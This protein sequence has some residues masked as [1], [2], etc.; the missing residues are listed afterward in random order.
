MPL[1]PNVPGYEI[2]SELGRG[3][4]GVVYRA[5]QVSLN[6]PV[7]LKM[8]LAG[9]LASP[10]DVQRF[11]TEA[12]AAAN[13]DHPHVVPI[14]EVGEHEGQHYFGMKLIEGGSLGDCLPH[15]RGDP[16]EAARLLR[17]AARA[18]HYAH[19]RGL[20]HRDLKPANIL[21][22]A[23]GEP[24]VT[25]FGLAKR[26][27]S[28]GREP[29][30]DLTRTGA[31]VGTPSYM[32]P[33][34]AR[35]EKGLSTAVDVYSLGAI[36]YE[37]LT[38]HPPFH[39]ATPL[40]TILQVLEREPA[41]PR[42]LNP[43]A[44]RDL[45]TIS[46]KCLEK[47]PSRRYDSAAALADDLGRWLRGEPITARA[48]GC[49]E[50]SW[51][52]CRRNP[53]LAGLVVAVVLFSVAVTYFAIQGGR[54]AKA[55]EAKAWQALF[56]QARAERLAGNR[57]GSLE[58]IREALKI[59][60]TLELREQAVQTLVSPGIQPLD[61]LPPDTE[62]V[63]EKHY[64]DQTIP[65][66]L[67]AA[68]KGAN[69][70]A[71]SA[72]RRSAILERPDT[73][74]QTTALTLWDMRSGQ[75]VSRLGAVAGVLQQYDCGLSQDGRLF[76]YGSYRL[77]PLG[78][79]RPVPMDDKLRI[80]DTRSGK[81]QAEGSR[82]I[83]FGELWT[84]VGG[85]SP[86]FSPDGALLAGTVNANGGMVSAKGGNPAVRVWDV[87]TGATVGEVPW[88]VLTP[89]AWSSDGRLLRARAQ[90]SP[91]HK[92]WLVSGPP[93]THRVDATVS[94]LSFRPDGKQLVVNA[95]L[96]DVA[97][98]RGRLRLRPSLR[99]LPGSA[100]VFDSS[101]RLWAWTGQRFAAVQLI[102]GRIR[103]DDLTV[104]EINKTSE[105]RLTWTLR[106]SRHAP[107]YED[108][109]LGFSRDGHSVLRLRKN[110]G[111]NV[112]G[113]ELWDLAAGRKVADWEEAPKL[114][115]VNARPAFSS[116]G[117][118]VA[119]G[120]EGWFGIWKVSSGQLLHRVDLRGL[121]RWVNSVN[122]V[123]APP[124][125][126]PNGQRVFVATSCGIGVCDVASGEW[127]THWL[128]RPGSDGMLVWVGALAISP[129]GRLAATGNARGRICLVETEEG[130]ELACWE[131]QEG[132]VTALTFSPD[133]QAL[134]SG[135]G[136]NFKVWDLPRIREGL[137]DLGFDW[138][139]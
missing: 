22:D 25:D 83:L 138:P 86:T 3:G 4:M 23:K 62:F 55:A 131:A 105:K 70:L 129:D 6:R 104:Y 67:A 91:D 74:R 123:A 103:Y 50:R 93:V 9:Q 106:P 130:R 8:I 97:G 5:W 108:D 110:A 46:L 29:G 60:N 28:A 132:P 15:F 134:V 71:I 77:G 18:V 135:G 90:H 92:A 81:V 125:F 39:A 63:E 88:S 40:D 45:A 11:H 69:C 73:K 98:E 100:A 102:D 117:D 21:L 41:H 10:Q 76:A 68:P 17:T 80:V 115:S 24:H 13:L 139:E 120:G 7:A 59:N 94:T 36:L 30:E 89:A 87:S 101:A 124:V 133:G 16:R 121:F 126:S 128:G 12:E 65:P 34:Q 47:E 31:I 109:L 33:E 116:D 35:A 111:D 113:L 107:D 122:P 44:D 64:H 38:G 1:H 14:Y 54:Q 49:V 75:Q 48:V 118:L 137:S 53:A 112:V 20:L 96:W 32:A 52:W 99:A 78:F 51:R 85:S 58:A 119:C 61:E 26:V 127:Q 37:L 114:R 66:E 19:Q 136:G 2:L 84:E 95:S 57:A 56:A 82:A 72:D 79:V 43:G 27:A 42:S